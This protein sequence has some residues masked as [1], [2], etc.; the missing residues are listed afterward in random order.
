MHAYTTESTATILN[1]LSPRE[2]LT[3]VQKVDYSH[4]DQLRTLLKIWSDGRRLIC[5]DSSGRVDVDTTCR[6]HDYW[7]CNPTQRLDGL[8]PDFR[9]CSVDDLM[10]EHRERSPVTGA[11]L[12]NGC[13]P[14]GVNWDRVSRHLWV[15]YPLGRLT[16][17]LSAA[18]KEQ[19]VYNALMAYPLPIPFDQINKVRARVKD[20]QASPEESRHF[21]EA[22]AVLATEIR[23]FAGRTE[24]TPPVVHDFGLDQ[25]IAEI[26]TPDNLTITQRAN[27]T[28]LLLNCQSMLSNRNQ[29]VTQLSYQSA[30]PEHADALSH[31]RSILATSLQ[32]FSGFQE[33]IKVLA[34]MDGDTVAFEELL[35]FL[36]RLR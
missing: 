22:E 19:D 3:L 16:G 21:M 31:T 32:Y 26:K 23:V 6:M 35:R 20:G 24:T 15:L 2:W 1:S 9:L 27:L 33:L 8:V 29:I 17:R 25:Q 28:N 10:S 11:E 13:S 36:K 34:T 12:F 14:N 4:R 7:L 30:I 5:V 18:M